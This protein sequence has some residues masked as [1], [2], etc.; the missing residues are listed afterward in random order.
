MNI[1]SFVLNVLYSIS[2][3]KISFN[4]NIFQV[5]RSIVLLVVPYY[6]FDVVSFVAKV[7]LSAVE[8]EQY[9]EE[10]EYNCHIFIF[11]RVTHK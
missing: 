7:C 6:L 11:D 2:I 8:V 9:W 1:I 10:I 4:I 3:L 5:S